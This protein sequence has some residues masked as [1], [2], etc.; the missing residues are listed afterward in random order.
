MTLNG[1]A[2]IVTEYEKCCDYWEY[3]TDPS[4]LLQWPMY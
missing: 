2:L 1:K 3:H 4:I